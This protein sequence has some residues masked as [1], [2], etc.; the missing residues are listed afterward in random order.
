MHDAC[1]QACALSC[2]CA[3]ALHWAIACHGTDTHQRHQLPRVLE[4]VLQLAHG[5]GRIEKQM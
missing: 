3:I 1:M 2:S 5:G 4:D